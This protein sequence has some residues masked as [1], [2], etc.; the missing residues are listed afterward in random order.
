MEELGT[1]ISTTGKDAHGNLLKGEGKRIVKH[2]R[3][4]DEREKSKGKKTIRRGMKYARRVMNMAER[5]QNK[6]R[7]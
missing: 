4:L 1:K 2:I 5:F 7:W 3:K 6:K